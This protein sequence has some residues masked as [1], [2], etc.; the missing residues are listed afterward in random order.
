MLTY[1]ERS[2]EMS[3]KLSPTVRGVIINAL[4]NK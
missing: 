4:K 1:E 2:K 3:E